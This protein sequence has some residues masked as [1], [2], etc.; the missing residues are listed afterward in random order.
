MSIEAGG[1][2]R[3]KISPSTSGVSALPPTVS[4]FYEIT[5]SLTTVEPEPDPLGY[6]GTF[7]NYT[8]NFLNKP[9]SATSVSDIGTPNQSASSI[10]AN[11]S[12][13]I[14]MSFTPAMDNDSWDLF[15][16]SYGEQ[17]WTLEVTTTEVT[18]HGPIGTKIS[19]FWPAGS[20]G[21]FTTDTAQLPVPTVLPGDPVWPT[22]EN[23]PPSSAS[24]FWGDAPT[25]ELTIGG[26][27]PLPPDPS[28]DSYQALSVYINNGG[29]Q[30][31]QGNTY[32]IQNA[33]E[34]GL[35]GGNTTG[36]QT[37]ATTTLTN[38][39]VTGCL[40]PNLITW[41]DIGSGVYKGI[42]DADVLAEPNWSN[43]TRW[44]M[45][46]RD[47]VAN[48]LQQMR[49]TPSAEVSPYRYTWTE[50]WIWFEDVAG[51][52]NEGG[53]TV[54]IASGTTDVIESVTFP[55]TSAGDALFTALDN[56]CDNAL[57]NN[58]NWQNLTIAIHTLP[59]VIEFTT[60]ATWDLSTRTMTF[61]KA[62]LQ[63]SDYMKFA[64]SGVGS[65][66]DSDAISNLDAGEYMMNSSNGTIYYKPVNA[67]AMSGT[68]QIFV[69]AIAQMLKINGGGHIE[70]DGV[71]IFGSKQGISA[72]PFF[73][74]GRLSEDN[75]LTFSNCNIHR[76]IEGSKDVVLTISGCTV[77]E[78]IN[79]AFGGTRMTI[80]ESYFGISYNKSV[81]SATAAD[82][83][84]N[85][86]EKNFFNLRATAHGQVMANYTGAWQNVQIK[87][88]IFFNCK[89]I[90]SYQPLGTNNGDPATQGTFEVAN[91]L[92]YTEDIAVLPIPQGQTGIAFNGA[93]DV[94]LTTQKVKYLSNTIVMEQDFKENFADQAVQ[95]T[96]QTSLLKHF[97]SQVT[98]AN[99]IMP[100]VRHPT[101]SSFDANSGAPGIKTGHASISNA[102]Y[103][104]CAV[105]P[106]DTVNAGYGQTDM[107]ELP[108]TTGSN[109][110]VDLTGVFDMPTL[111]PSGAWSTG[112]TDNGAIGVRWS[113]IPTVS[114]ITALD[115]AQS[116]TWWQT[117]VPGTYPDPAYPT[118]PLDIVVA[119]DDNRI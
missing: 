93:T 80:T 53:M 67:T 20:L 14:L 9:Y 95:Q 17:T 104:R 90:L 68:P 39:T 83:I 11:S 59:N 78:M 86:V 119:G 42:I 56:G 62:G 34:L 6:S 54:A 44:Q 79:R 40:N 118:D 38:G 27:S 74:I 36:I 91:N 37:T 32:T 76:L 8:D 110:T 103:G 10:I 89:Q 81:L 107:A 46:D 102:K 51:G 65:S 105:S 88:N 16:Q 28:L 7:G 26:T 114:Q 23:T 13:G 111:T 106:T 49:P 30:D 50:D 101:Q 60:V 24:D 73:V 87:N 96:L 75:F 70:F 113:S 45:V 71:E 47:Q 109:I 64:W 100:S 35:Y 99:N 98:L 77:N 22:V 63:Y 116:T 94:D 3:I 52:E 112:A 31:L 85:L 92:I 2:D 43:E 115:S 69:P 29:T 97:C 57:S 108:Y 82:G 4:L 84:V 66:S 21:R 61:T 33:Y 55:A 12:S 117:Y 19:Y 18:D 15:E 41:T 1:G 48:P 72:N 58:A 25:F 5:E